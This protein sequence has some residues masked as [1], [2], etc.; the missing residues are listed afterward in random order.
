[1]TGQLL[2]GA[3]EEGW[4]RR[5]SLSL[6]ESAGFFNSR[7]WLW[8]NK[9][10]WIPSVFENGYIPW[11]VGHFYFLGPASQQKNTQHQGHIASTMAPVIAPYNH[12]FYSDFEY[13]DQEK[14]SPKIPGTCTQ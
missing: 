3:G 1:V 4:W 6:S 11:D 13:F 2:A 12:P 5:I 10:W 8:H 9:F 7:F 14:Q